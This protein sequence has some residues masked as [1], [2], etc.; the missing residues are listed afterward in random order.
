M[1]EESRVEFGEACL[2]RMG[3]EVLGHVSTRES[4]TD[5]DSIRRA[6]GEETISYFG[7]SYGSELGATWAT[8]FPDTVR[9]AVLDGASDP[10]APD[11]ENAAEAGRRL[12]GI[13]RHLPGGVRR[14][15]GLRVPQRR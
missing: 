11:Y 5:M 8:L 1:A 6:L 4:A 10:T 3:A 2:R 9:A 12:R 13:A 14:R 7:F 15:H